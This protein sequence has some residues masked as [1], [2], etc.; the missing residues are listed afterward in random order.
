LRLFLGF[1]RGARSSIIYTTTTQHSK[2]HNHNHTVITKLNGVQPHYAHSTDKSLNISPGQSLTGSC[3]FQEFP[4]SPAI[5]TNHQPH[6]HLTFMDALIILQRKRKLPQP[7]CLA[8]QPGRMHV[9]PLPQLPA[10]PTVPYITQICTSFLPERSLLYMGWC[11][12][13]STTTTFPLPFCP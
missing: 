6:S 7:H 4:S 9:R 10:A 13:P 5:N 1:G 11:R 8:S 3:G 2:E 12:R